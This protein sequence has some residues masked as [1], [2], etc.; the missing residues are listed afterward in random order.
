M[1]LSGNAHWILR[2]DG[3]AGGGATLVMGR[4]CESHWAI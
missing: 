3:W 1:N 4:N 2:K